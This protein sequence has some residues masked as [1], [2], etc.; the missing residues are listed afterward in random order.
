MMRRW[1][2]QRATRKFLS[3]RMAVCALLIVA[4]YFLSQGSH[5]NVLIKY[6]TTCIMRKKMRHLQPRRPQRVRCLC[7]ENRTYYRCSSVVFARIK[8][9]RPRFRPT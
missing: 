1:M 6:R 7:F 5:R 8:R 4:I 2:Q 3:N 9:R